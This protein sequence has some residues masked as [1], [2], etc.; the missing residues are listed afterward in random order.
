M[1]GLTFEWP[2]TASHQHSDDNRQQHYIHQ[3]ARQP[4]GYEQQNSK[5]RP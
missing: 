2:V 5:Q 1:S 4:P 3:H